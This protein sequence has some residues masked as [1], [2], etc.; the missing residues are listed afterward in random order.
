[1][2]FH[3]EFTRIHLLGW[4]LV[5]IYLVF[6]FISDFQ[7]IQ[8]KYLFIVELMLTLFAVYLLKAV[9]LLWNFHADW[10]NRISNIFK[11]GDHALHAQ[12]HYLLGSLIKG[13]FLWESTDVFVITS[14][15]QTFFFPEPEN[16]NFGDWK[17][18]RN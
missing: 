15:R 16:L 5:A 18:L 13:T 11:L 12:G 17:L 7:T 4:I 6:Q 3:G 1:M 9:V 14:D 2:N 8:A 10:R